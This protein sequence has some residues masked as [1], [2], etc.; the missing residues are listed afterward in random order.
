VGNIYWDFPDIYA[1]PLRHS[2]YR[3]SAGIVRQGE[4]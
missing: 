3:V 4:L 1:L 2:A